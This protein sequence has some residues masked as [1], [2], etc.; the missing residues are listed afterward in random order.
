MT[1]S[2]FHHKPDTTN[3]ADGDCCSAACRFE[4]NGSACADDGNVC[5]NDVCNG[6]GTC[7]H[8][9]N[10][11]SCDDGLF[12]N[13]TD[14]CSGGT[15]IH[16]GDPCAGAAQCANVCNEVGDTCLVPPGTPCAPDG[17]ICTDDVC[18]GTGS[19]VHLNNTAPC[20]DGIACTEGDICSFGVCAGTPNSALCIAENE[21]LVASCA[22]AVG[23]TSLAIA[24]GTPCT[25]D[26]DACTE[27][28]CVAGG[29]VHSPGVSC[30]EIGDVDCDGTRATP[31]D[32][33]V[34]FCLDNGRCVDADVPT[35]CDD[36]AVRRRRS[37]WDLSGA[38]DSIDAV[39]TLRLFVGRLGIVDTELGSCC[40]R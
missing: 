34:I 16:S 13:G 31:I 33:Q 12:C 7:A 3:Q 29:C 36:P 6:A 1:P 20:D 39:T 9:N 18:N 21:C 14:T 15:C 35:P 26:G 37:D 27:D 2:L 11:A 19:C 30:M 10:A 8:P 25:D 4:V 28:V 23:C 32:A 24:D 38:V 40:G 22:A 17:S 5:T